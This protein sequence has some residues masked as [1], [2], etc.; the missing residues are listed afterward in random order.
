[1]IAYRQDP[2]RLFPE[3]RRPFHAIPPGEF[4]RFLRAH[5]A[6][7]PRV[8]YQTAAMG[9]IL[10]CEK[11]GAS[12]VLEEMTP[13]RM[14]FRGRHIGRD[15]LP[16]GDPQDI[17]KQAPSGKGRL[18]DRE[19]I[20]L[21]D[22]IMSL[23]GGH[24]RIVREAIRGGID[25]PSDTVEHYLESYRKAIADNESCIRSHFATKAIGTDKTPDQIT[26][27]DLGEWSR[28][29]VLRLRAENEEAEA[30]IR[31]LTAAKLEA[32]GVKP[33]CGGSPDTL[34]VVFQAP[35]GVAPAAPT[36]SFPDVD[37][38]RRELLQVWLDGLSPNTLRA[39]RSKADD[40][41]R[42]LGFEDTPRGVEWLF[43]QDA[44]TANLVLKRYRDHLEE[45]EL[46]PNT[47]N[48]HL[49][50]IRSLGKIARIVGVC[51]WRLEVPGPRTER[52][53]DTRGPGA[54]GWS[55]M[56]Q[57]AD[58]D[59]TPQG[60]RDRAIVC[61]AHDLALRRGEIA[62]LDLCH[63]AIETEQNHGMVTRRVASIEVMAKGKTERKRLTV[64]PATSKALVAWI[65]ARGEHPGSLFW[66][67]D[68]AATEDRGRLTGEAIRLVCQRLSKAAG[69]PK[70][71]KPH[72][73]RHAGITA[74]LDAN[75]GDVRSAAKFSRHA[76]LNVLTHYDDER[77]D[78]FG[79][80]AE[81]VA[82]D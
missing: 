61:L 16:H 44:G 50:A 80:M 59:Q 6:S 1:M 36:R 34:P 40:L 30:I 17:P 51:N 72:G 24:I 31:E 68:R 66:R 7:L 37:Q 15:G 47:V 42:F 5:L 23:S 49:N 29:V 14:K 65:E 18:P 25:V 26:L 79:Q 60:I 21:D 73:L 78:V 69:L 76:N 3:E 9:Q 11:S 32:M 62:S 74:C 8:T 19:F 13:K 70:S 54:I 82:G 41:A 28:G 52:L 71:C 22:L 33:V 27:D 63:V 75:G 53:R 56:R 46:S 57:A 81:L 64:P 58:R 20:V 4:S 48:L 10:Y 55:K 39:Y 38:R 77:R 43:E 12:W 2:T 35:E 45:R 67:L